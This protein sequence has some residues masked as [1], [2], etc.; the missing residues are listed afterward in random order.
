MNRSF[1]DLLSTYRVAR[2]QARLRRVFSQ[3]AFAAAL[4]QWIRWHLFYDGTRV[5]SAVCTGVDKGRSWSTGPDLTVAELGQPETLQ[6]KTKKLL[7]QAKNGGLGVVLHLADQFDQCIVQEEFEKPE[8]FEQASAFVRESPARVVTDVLQDSDRSIQWRYYPLLSG[9]R[10]VVLR[11]RFEFLAA[12]EAL[13]D[14]DIKIAIHSAPVEM[15]ALY[16]KLY[17]Q[18]SEEKPHC[19]VFFYDRFT[20]VAPVYHGV[21]DFRVL[22][23]RQ[24]AVPL[25]FGDDLFSLLE[26][27]GFVGSCTLLLVPC[28]TQEPTLL[29]HELDTYARRNQKNVDG[30]EI[31]IPDNE[32]LWSVLNG[33]AYGKLDRSIV[34]RPEFLTDYNE[35]SGK[36]FPHSLGIQGDVQR[37][38]ILTRETFWPDDAE[39]RQRKLPKSFAMLMIGLRFA[40]I[41][42]AFLLIGLAIWFGIFVTTVNNGEALRALPEIIAGKRSE[43]DQLNNTKQYL[44][45]WDKILTPRSQAWSTMDFLLGLLPEGDGVLWEKVAYAIKQVDAKTAAKKESGAAGAFSREWIIDGIC[46]DQGRANLQRLQETATLV[47]LF[48]SA[49]V[50][51][52]DASFTVSGYRTVKADL[53]E[54][55]NSQPDPKSQATSLAYKFRLVV[56]EI[57]PG[58][59]LLAL[60]TL[61][62]LKKAAM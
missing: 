56:T 9:Q 23:H 58:N 2:Q 13:T 10:A 31:Q 29:F 33:F 50:R 38:W 60:P 21:L 25:T 46:N 42:C 30:I 48:N 51:L 16:L 27:L 8:V 18:P 54:E 12:F 24:E 39:Y 5:V 45:K 53:R 7:Q 34:Q 26:K 61:P 11:H 32:A 59:D 14:C 6:A 22:A 43:F 3:H 41:A 55:A 57:F 4:D 36:E 35:W 17:E 28:G 49:A 40:R 19:F 37:F 44:T 62:K 1:S 15:L 20:V 52:N 47:E